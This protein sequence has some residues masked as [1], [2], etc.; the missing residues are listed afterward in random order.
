MEPEACAARPGDASAIARISRA[1]FPDPWPEGL[2]HNQLRRR[3]TR[4]WVARDARKGVVGYV[5]GWRVLDEV[6]V[7]SLAVDPSSRRRGVGR[8]LLN[9]YLETLRSEGVREITLEVRASN[10]VAHEFYREFGFEVQGARPRYYPG[11]E[12]AVLLGAQL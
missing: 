2:F 7:L 3:E 10:S 4:T 6:Q 11:G 8:A 5:L 9:A 12:T 1:S